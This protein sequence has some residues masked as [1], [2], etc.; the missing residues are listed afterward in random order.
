MDFKKIEIESVG[1]LI[2]LGL[3][4]LVVVGVVHVVFGVIINIGMGELFKGFSITD[5]LLFLI[6]L[7]QSWMCMN[8][9]GKSGTT[10]KTTSKK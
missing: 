5:T 6:F 9:T 2:I 7:T 4:L 8:T 3:I 1:P 10:K